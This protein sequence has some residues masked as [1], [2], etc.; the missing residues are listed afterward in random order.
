MTVDTLSLAQQLREAELSPTQAEAIA[1]AI[2][3]ALIEG[4]ATKADVQLVRGDLESAKHELKIE[5]ERTR[6]QI[7]LWYVSTQIA[8]GALIVALLKL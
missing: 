2:G 3:R 5:I 4:A 7:L 6:N 1:T 8:L